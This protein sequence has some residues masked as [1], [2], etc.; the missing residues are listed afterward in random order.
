[1]N[2]YL[3]GQNNFGNRGCEAL[4]RS[5]LTVLRQ[6]D[7]QARVLVPS[8]DLPRD[9]AQ[10]P[11]AEQQG[12]KFVPVPALPRRFAHWN[13]VVS[14]LPA[15]AALPWPR[16]P[17]GDPIRAQLRDCDMLLSIGGD[18]YSLDYDLGSL[19][20]FVA[21][22]EAAL[23]M[24]KPA[25]LWG[26][27]AGP[28]SRLPA[29]ERH[30]AEHLKRL[31]AVTVRETHTHAYLR[32]LGLKDNL[33]LVADS[34]FLLG[35]EAV[36]REGFWPE[37]EDGVLGLNLSPLVDGVRKRAGASSELVDEAVRFVEGVVAHTR[38]GVLL[39]P[40]VA[41][42]DGS[43]FNNDEIYLAQLQQ[44]LQSLGGRV[45]SVP[46][47]M[48]GCQLK[49]VIAGCRYFI[50]ARTHATI[51]ALSSG[52]PTVSIAYSIKARG[53]NLDLFD[54]EDHVLDTRKVDAQS[55]QQALDGL[56]HQEA[57]IRA[58]LAERL[59]EWRKRAARGA[60]LVNALL[61]D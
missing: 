26:A 23:E 18:N 25:L 3:T 48:N 27:S 37:G 29:V 22:A 6:A 54:H 58:H 45:R 32:G 41:P 2:I 15:L 14:R 30:M 35:R 61:K 46:G 60:D 38:L 50:G 57:A 47:G 21:I 12:A 33:H 20:Y 16:L 56:V 1:M 36:A 34:A 9:R 4:V 49:D 17:A 39:V 31:S 19:A 28:F 43:T 42:L 11:Q 44:R 10:W 40:H 55:L 51:A 8:A 24:G 7:G 5:T 13:R 59:P 52:V 53:I